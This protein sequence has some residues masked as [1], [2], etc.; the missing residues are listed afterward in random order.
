MYIYST[1]LFILHAIQHIKLMWCVL[2]Y[3]CT[4]TLFIYTLNTHSH[5]RIVSMCFTIARSILSLCVR[6][7][8]TTARSWYCSSWC[9]GCQGGG[10]SNHPLRPWKQPEAGEGAAENVRTE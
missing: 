6:M 3:H 7:C 9:H 2:H 5:I 10:V 4:H 8:S 1:G